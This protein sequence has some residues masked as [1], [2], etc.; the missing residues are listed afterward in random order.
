MCGVVHDYTEYLCSL[1][2]RGGLPRE[3][4]YT[5]FTAYATIAD[6][7]LIAGDGRLLPVAT[8]VNEYARP[9]LTMT[10]PWTD[11][12]KAAAELRAAGRQEWG[13]VELE[14]TPNTRT[15]EATLEHFDWL[16]SRGARVLC[17]FG[18]WDAEGSMFAVRGTGAV[19]GIRRWL[20]DTPAAQ[21]QALP[22]KPRPD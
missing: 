4:I 9:G 13:A 10:Q 17:L 20:A 16:A 21:D 12:E 1:C 8:A 5:H 19:A 6:P 22:P 3:R 15:E 7:A 11:R 18:W 2:V 14:V